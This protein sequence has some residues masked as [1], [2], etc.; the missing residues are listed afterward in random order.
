MNRSLIAAAFAAAAIATPAF[1]ATSTFRMDVEYS[2]ANL[3]TP[4]S[5]A[6]EYAHIRDQVSDRCEAEHADMKYGQDFAVRACTERTLT[7]TVRAI[8]DKNLSE[9]HANR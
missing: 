8:G 6:K 9:I 2:K 4:A 5:A 3:A 7:N 1:A